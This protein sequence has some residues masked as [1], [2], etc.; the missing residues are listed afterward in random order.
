ME[1]QWEQNF[2]SLPL[3]IVIVSF[4]TFSEFS[5]H[6]LSQNDIGQFWNLDTCY[7]NDYW[8]FSL[9]WDQMELKKK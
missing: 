5:F 6:W 1:P 9:T 3:Q 4:Q 8:S 2:H 7:F